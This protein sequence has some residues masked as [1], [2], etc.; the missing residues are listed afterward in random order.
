M[1]IREMVSGPLVALQM[2]ASGNVAMLASNAWIAA[3]VPCPMQQPVT[4]CIVSARRFSI[5]TR[6]R[7]R[8]QLRRELGASNSC[9]NHEPSRHGP[10]ARQRDRR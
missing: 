4:E 1:A 8:S 3:M 5:A 7:A 9:A 2:S 10:R 6:L